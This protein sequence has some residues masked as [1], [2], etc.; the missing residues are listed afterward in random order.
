MCSCKG[1]MDKLLS[2]D[3]FAK[4]P[5]LRLPNGKKKYNTCIGWL[6]TLIYI[7]AL[8]LFIQSTVMS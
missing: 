8:V 2:S 7:A 1:M 6:C 3:I 5:E 4:K